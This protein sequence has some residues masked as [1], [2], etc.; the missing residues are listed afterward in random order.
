MTAA[1]CR[2]ALQEELAKFDGMP[3]NPAEF[4]SHTPD[5]DAEDYIAMHE[6]F[7]PLEPMEE[8]WCT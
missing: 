3:S 7:Y 2:E 5:M 8:R 4:E 1:E 6:S